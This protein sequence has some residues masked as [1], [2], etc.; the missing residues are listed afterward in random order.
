[1]IFSDGGRSSG[2]EETVV[3]SRVRSIVESGSS[4]RGGFLDGMAPDV[5]TNDGDVAAVSESGADVGM[6][7]LEEDAGV[8]AAADAITVP[9]WVDMV[10][11]FLS[12]EVCRSR[13]SF[14]VDPVVV[15]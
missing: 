4:D 8:D 7:A 10:E 9:Y 1:M 14:S 2:D 3:D 6:V 5:A 15:W 13:R 12:D 11:L